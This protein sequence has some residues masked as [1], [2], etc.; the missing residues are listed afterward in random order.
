WKRLGERLA[1]I[2]RP[3]LTDVYP[4]FDGLFRRKTFQEATVECVNQRWLDRYDGARDTWAMLREREGV[5]EQSCRPLVADMYKTLIATVDQYAMAVSLLVG[6]KPFDID[7]HGRVLIEPVGLAEA[8]E[9][10]RKRIKSLVARLT[11][12]AQMPRFEEAFRF[13]V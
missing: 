1:S 5:V 3:S 13:E 12:P 4:E 9:Q 7:V 6:S 2:A 10:S 11:D 8:C